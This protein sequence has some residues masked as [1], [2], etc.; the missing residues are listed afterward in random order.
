MK[1]ITTISASVALSL[2]LLISGCEPLRTLLH[3]PLEKVDLQVQVK[4]NSTSGTYDLTGLADL[5]DSS[6][7]RIAAIRYLRPT[8][9]ASQ[10]LNPKPTYAILDYQ[11]A[12]VK[13]G[14]WQ[15]QLNL[16]QVAADGRYQEAWQ[17]H[18]DA[19]KLPTSPESDVGPIRCGWWSRPSKSRGGSLTRA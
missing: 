13:G 3:R 11:S 9:P 7:I 12:L 2:S 16:W 1:R 8:N 14:K 17:I 18:Q 6:P 19:L 5:P 15:G 10:K 4:P